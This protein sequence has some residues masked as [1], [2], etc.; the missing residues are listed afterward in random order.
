MS[1]GRFLNKSLL[2]ILH[3]IFTRDV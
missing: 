2:Q 1:T 3:M